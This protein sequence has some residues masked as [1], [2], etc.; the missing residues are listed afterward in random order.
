M[1]WYVGPTTKQHGPK[2]AV[3]KLNILFT[4]WTFT[5][6]LCLCSCD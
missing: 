5:F 6:V 1:V 4:I 3:Y 2:A